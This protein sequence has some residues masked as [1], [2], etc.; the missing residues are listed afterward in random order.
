MRAGVSAADPG[1]VAFSTCR[2]GPCDTHS[3]LTS[4]STPTATAQNAVTTKACPNERSIRTDRRVRNR[5]V[6]EKCRDAVHELRLHFAHRHPNPLNLPK[7]C[8]HQRVGLSGT[9][10]NN[11]YE[12]RHLG[13][14]QVRSVDRQLPFQAEIALRSRLRV[15]RDDRDKQ[16]TVPDLL[17]DLIVPDVTAPEFGLIEPNFNS[18][19]A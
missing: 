10:H 4:A 16:R 1:A 18:G 2:T 12:E 17:T 13:S 3:L 7:L 15:S 9:V 6:I 5:R 19:D 8:R 14:H 11:R